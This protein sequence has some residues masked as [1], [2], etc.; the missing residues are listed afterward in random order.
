[1]NKKYISILGSVL[2]G[3]VGSVAAYAEEAPVDA[4]VEAPK[5]AKEIRACA[6]EN[7]P[8]TTSIQ[9]LVMTAYDRSGG[10]RALK[11]KM[12]W[13]LDKN[14]YSNVMIKVD[15]PRDLSGSSYLVLERETKDDMFMYL[16]AV[17]RVRRIVGNMKSDPL[18]GTDLSY[19]DIKQ[20][21]G[22]A[23]A[24]TLSR[25]DDAEVGSRKTYVIQT[26]YEEGADSAY[27]RV[28]TNIDQVTC[29]P[30]MVDFYDLDDIA[31]KQLTVNPETMT[32]DGGKWQIRDADMQ[33]LHQKTHTEIKVEDIQT[34]A[35]ISSRVFNS[36]SFYR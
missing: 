8:T 33:N 7:F 27:S 30:L 15:S 29:M 11:A 18:W 16:P 28:V 5:T 10:S 1:M 14:G 9:S 26:V 6:R 4:G 2:L 21:Q 35:E 23:L 13:R 20:L 17:N 24:G 36:Q 3:L 12:H 19:E 34:D 32:E 22:V 31:V 25:L